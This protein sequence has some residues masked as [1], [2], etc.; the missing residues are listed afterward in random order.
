MNGLLIGNIIKLL[1]K[2]MLKDKLLELFTLVAFAF[3]LVFGASLLTIA[4]LIILPL[5]ILRCMFGT[6]KN[7]N[8]SV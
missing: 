5:G 2:V 1:N 4:M 6:T 8:E 7:Q 3:V